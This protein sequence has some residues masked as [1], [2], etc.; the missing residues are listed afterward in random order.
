MIGF[1]IDEDRRETKG[2]YVVVRQADGVISTR[3]ANEEAIQKAAKTAS[4]SIPYAEPYR[5]R[6]IATEYP[7]YGRK[8]IED[9]LKHGVPFERALKVVP[10]L[11]DPNQT[12]VKIRAVLRSGQWLQIGQRICRPIDRSIGSGLLESSRL[13]WP[14][15]WDSRF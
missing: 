12:A 6:A 5:E 3:W 7:E 11:T 9:A 1:P 4:V 8:L 13:Y 15:P 14:S 2:R 10:F